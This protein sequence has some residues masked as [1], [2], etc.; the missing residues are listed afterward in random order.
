MDQ[1]G[2]YMRIQI[3]II[4][5]MIL[6]LNVNC[7]I[8]VPDYENP[9]KSSKL[10]MEMVKNYHSARLDLEEYGMNNPS[11]ISGKNP[12]AISVCLDY[13]LKFFNTLKNLEYQNDKAQ[14]R[15]EAQ[16]NSKLFVRNW[17]YENGYIDRLMSRDFDGNRYN[18]K[19]PPSSWLINTI[20][21][22]KPIQGCGPQYGSSPLNCGD[23]TQDIRNDRNNGII[24]GMGTGSNGVD[25]EE[26]HKVYAMGYFDTD[27]NQ[28]LDKYEV[29]AA[30]D[31][32]Y[33][34]K[35]KIDLTT[36][37]S[38]LNLRN[39]PL[40]ISILPSQTEIRDVPI[41]EGQTSIQEPTD[42]ASKGKLRDEL[43]SDVMSGI[44]T[45]YIIQLPLSTTNPTTSSPPTG[46][47]TTTST[48]TADDW[49]K[50]GYA[51]AKQGK[52]DDAIQAFD[53]AIQ[54]NPNF[55]NAWNNKG[56]ILAKQ[57]KYDDAIQACDKAIQLAPK[58]DSVWSIKG[59]ALA[60]QGKYDDA[61]QAFD[62][63]IQLDPQD[64]FDWYAKGWVLDNQDKYGEAI[65]CLDEAI[66]L[67]P[68]YA[69]AWHNKG[70]AL[71]ALGRSSEADAAFAKAKEMGYTG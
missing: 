22:D 58:N 51:L 26:R 13:S 64:T 19:M 10:S 8:S 63:A 11:P 57:G 12:V 55:A 69:S 21:F 70:V 65:K 24:L 46:T 60:K 42:Q 31:E 25:P 5:F 18:E 45:T 38:V 14:F 7:V 68:N 59:Y 9:Q 17:W 2:E 35:N 36:L 61:I 27:G 23:I 41:T 71:E 32:W 1:D 33:E 30:I 67:D 43:R 66:R 15:E 52:Y 44:E 50:K 16:E 54:L 56:W 39:H 29:L 40:K 4:I 47:T 49:Y 37:V 53:K 48:P 62:K 20:T 34:N 6:L 28:A 3:C